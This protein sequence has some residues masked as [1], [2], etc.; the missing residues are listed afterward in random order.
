MHTKNQISLTRKTLYGL[1]IL[2]MMFSIFDSY[3]ANAQSQTPIYNDVSANVAIIQNEI[4]IPAG[5]VIYYPFDE[6]TAAGFPNKNYDFTTHQNNWRYSID[7]VLHSGYGGGLSSEAN[8]AY[9]YPIASGKV[10]K[11]WLSPSFGNVVYISHEN[12]LGKEFVSMYAHM[13]NLPLVGKDNLV[14]VNTRLGIQGNTGKGS[15]NPNPVHLHLSLLYC[16]NPTDATN[17]GAAGCTP[18]RPEPMIGKYA[19]EKFNWWPRNDSTHNEGIGAYTLGGGR[20]IAPN[21]LNDITPPEEGWWNSGTT[22][23]NSAANPLSPTQPIIFDIHAGDGGSGIGEIRLTANYSGWH[24]NTEGAWRIIARCRPGESS[25]CSGGNW[26]YTWNWATE[27]KP[28]DLTP[29]EEIPWMTGIQKIGGGNQSVCISFDVFDLAGNPRYAPQGV[30][31][32]LN[33][34]GNSVVDQTLQDDVARLIYVNAGSPFPSADNAT[35][36]SDITLPDGTVVSPGQALT[37]TWRVKNI[38]TSTWGSGYQLAFTGG[39]QMGAPSAVDVPVT[40]PGQEVDISV[41]MTAPSGGG[42][43]WGNWRLRNPQGTYFGDELLVEVTV[44]DNTNPPPPPSDFTLSCL[45]CPASIPP[46]QT[47][48]PTIR[49]TIGS[50]QLLG[51]RGDSLR[52]TD[53]NLYG[54]WPHVA[55]VGTVNQ[56]YDFTFYAD[57]PIIAPNSDGAYQTKWRLWQNGQYVGP[58][59]TIAFQVQSGGG[60]TNHPPNAPSLTGPGDWAVFQGSGGI[61]LG[62]QQNGDPDGDAVSQY[63]FEIFESHDIPNS[64][65]ITSNSWSPPGLGFFGYQW[66][67]K[68]KDSRGAES[69]WSETRHFNINNPDPVIYDFHWEW[70]RDAWGGSEKV[71]FCAQTSGGGLE[72]KLNSASDGSDQGTWKVIGHG[73]TNLSCNNDNDRPPNWGQLENPPGTYRVRLYLRPNVGGWDAAKT[74]DVTIPLPPNQRPGSP[75]ILEPITPSYLSTTSVHFAWKTTYRTDDYHLMVSADPN[76]GSPLIDQHFPVGTTSFD[77]TFPTDY[78]NLYA[79]V[80]STGPYGTNDNHGNFHIDMTPPVSAVAPLFPVTYDTSFSVNW[81]GS[82]ARS[83]LRWYHVQVRDGNRSDSEWVDWLVNTT[84]IAELFSGQSG[85]TYYFRSR[86]MDK[87]GNWEN[88]PTGDGDSYTLVDPSAAPPTAWWDNAYAAKRNLI[89]LNSDGNNIPIHYPMHVHFDSSTS[90]SAAEV[91][92]AS[93]SST[94][95][96]DVRIVYNNQTELDRFVQRFTS[97]QIDLWFPLYAVLGGGQADNSSYQIYYGYAGATSPTVDINDIFLPVADANTIGLWHFQDGTGSTVTDTSGR[98]H[99]GTFYGPGWNDGWWGWAGS[100]DGFNSYVDAGTSNDFN[101]GSGPM[102]IE[103]WIY[104]TQDRRDWPFIVAKWDN[105]SNGSYY[106]HLNNDNKIHWSVRSAG[107]VTV[108]GGNEILVNHWYHVA[109][110]YDGINTMRIYLNGSERVSKTVS[111]AG[112]NST[113][114]LTIGWVPGVNLSRFIGYIQ[115]VRISNVQRTSFPYAVVTNAPSVAVGTIIMPPISGSPDLAV[116]GLS[117][118]PNTDGGALVQATIQNQGSANTLNG[119]YTDLYVDHLPTGAGDYT[120]SLRFW[121]N[122]PIGAGETVTLTTLVTNVSQLFPAAKTVQPGGESSV[123][124]YAQTDST[125]AVTEADNGNNIYTQGTTL[126]VAN[127]DGFENDGSLTNASLIPV[128]S[129]Q[130]HNFHLPG[131]TDWI[132][133]NAQAGKTYRLTTGTL[134]VSA[135]TYLYLY[136]TNG[137]TLISSN[138]DSNGSLASEIEWT[139]PQDGTYYALVKHWNP[140]TGGC[141]TQYNLNVQEVLLDAF[142]V[143]TSILR[144][145]TSPTSAASVNF[146][147]T[148]SES[149]NGVDTGDFSLTTSGVSGATV[150]GVSGTGSSYTVT[151]NTG[152]G[153]GTIRLDVVDDD[154]ILDAALNPLGGAGAGNG[155]F[156]TGETY[157]VSKSPTFSDVPINYWAWQYIERLYNAGITGGCSTSPLMYCPDS[158]ATR[159]QMA[160]FL[161]KGIHG[162]SYSPPAVGTGTGFTDVPND[163]WAAAWIKQLAEDGITSGCGIGLYCPNSKVTRAQMA[164]FLL[165]SKYGPTYSPPGIGAGTGFTDVPSDYWAAAWIKQLAAEGITGGCGTGLYCPDSPVTRAQMAVFLVKTFNLP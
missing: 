160:I 110:T 157:T 51:S 134:G 89:I 101:V 126:C 117:S 45:N 23:P 31:C 99:N 24:P 97:D 130:T 71:C 49:A 93:L 16:T 74:A 6:Q 10:L 150:S 22:S 141:G 78:E 36:I 79:K 17:D 85:H 100:F 60:G 145:D 149:V 77:Y 53:G 67:V 129:S 66:H 68:V 123:T 4:S 127:P 96:D 33:S 42:S 14:T 3:K 112:L 15:T 82:D 95:G 115:H 153:N 108:P 32:N 28:F 50:G 38:G 148:F 136:D 5:K 7:F 70:C 165:K 144:A 142:P 138:D 161:L 102:T 87:V 158:T 8:D 94:K 88:W 154:S 109:V 72:L 98:G 163:Y 11:S 63:Y 120:G 25:E 116:L 113:D 86:A 40:A 162:S 34:G 73:D 48:R 47:F 44:P 103:A 56:T 132:K 58:E 80:I 156:A 152:T 61:V 52:N 107:E 84:K 121:V 133:F 155:N 13:K 59:L 9:I 139:A 135:D 124:L 19:N 46:G 27:T 106:V 57:H 20:T 159:A 164:V 1:M 137:T 26:R 147:V 35:F 30:L 131:D 81:S 122:D 119:F 39:E 29:L 114:P 83:G 104:M 21:L 125:G 2:G 54:A 69:A 92:N 65:W 118:Y 105:G 76:F 146:T 143:V 111:G 64:G 12:S 151:V 62:A 55:V 43:H 18:V 91:Y 140:S 128:G 75:D 90:P 41:N 37:K